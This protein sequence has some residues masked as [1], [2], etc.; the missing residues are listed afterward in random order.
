[1]EKFLE[2]HNVTKQIHEEIK[3]LNR[4]VTKKE[5]EQLTQQRKAQA[6]TKHLKN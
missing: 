2:T 5:T 4:S 6:S 3:N 1:M